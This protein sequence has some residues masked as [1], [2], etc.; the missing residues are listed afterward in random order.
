MVQMLTREQ[1]ADQAIIH[2]EAFQAPSYIRNAPL[3]RSFELPTVLYAITA[4][5]F[6]AFIG[7]M[8]TGFA[9]PEM[10][11]PTAIFALFIVAFFVVPAIWVR[12]QPENPVRAQSWARFR[13]NGIET[14]YV[15]SAPAPQRARCS[16]CRC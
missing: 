2:P 7:I 12:L 15:M 1:I 6:L 5:L 11:I 9:H 8:G 14:A 16:S 4:G 3:D 10:I 13:A